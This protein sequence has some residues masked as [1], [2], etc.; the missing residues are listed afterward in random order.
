MNMLSVCLPDFP[1]DAHRPV[2]LA[3]LIRAALI[4]MHWMVAAQVLRIYGGWVHNPKWDTSVT[5]SKT[6]GT[7]WKRGWKECNSLMIGVGLWKTIWA[8]QSLHSWTHSSY[9]CLYWAFKRLAPLNFSSWVE[10]R[11]WSLAPQQETTGRWWL[12]RQSLSSVLLIDSESPQAPVNSSPSLS[13][14]RREILLNKLWATKQ[15]T[16]RTGKLERG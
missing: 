2:L 6:Q 11:S 15:T 1:A 10:R 8:Q 9:S 3:V 14:I 13:M 7:L 5:L 16:K 4:W 12:L